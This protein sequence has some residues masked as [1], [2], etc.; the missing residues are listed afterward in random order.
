[1][2]F[3]KMGLDGKRLPQG[4]TQE[5]FMK[6]KYALACGLALGV[7]CM[8]G[9]GGGSGRLNQSSV[10]VSGIGTVT[11]EPDMI[12]MNVA[13]SHSA[14]TTKA[15]QEEVSRRVKQTLQ[16]LKDANIPDK[17]IQTASLSFSPEYDY[18][19]RRI[20]VGQRAEQRI[21]FSMDDIS[22]DKVSGVID[23]LIL[24]NGIELNQINFSV[25]DPT[26]YFAKSRELAFQKAMEKATQYAELSKLKVRKVLNI[27]EDGPRQIMPLMNNMRMMDAAAGAK[28]MSS[29]ALPIGEL[30]VTTTISVMFLMD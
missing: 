20:L 21:A 4:S 16:V 1:M 28:E 17:N 18:A 30:E 19:G 24:I 7:V 29:T 25:K 22:D 11:A 27:S 6:T 3:Y 26:E 12:Q 2:Y 5:A 23:Q 9:C 10:S 8:A 15:A 13:L 14:Q